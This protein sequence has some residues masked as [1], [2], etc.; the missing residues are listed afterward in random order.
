NPQPST[1]FNSNPLGGNGFAQ[2][3]AQNNDSQ[4]QT[5]PAFPASPQ[6]QP[7]FS[8]VQQPANGITAPVFNGQPTAPTI[9]ANLNAGGFNPQV[10]AVP[11]PNSALPNNNTGNAALNSIDNG[12]FRPNQ[13]PA[14]GATGSPGIAGVASKFKGPSIKTYRERT[15][16]EE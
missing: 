13:A 3:P 16:Y 9:S 1:L 8:P 11:Q 7:P 15:K 12:L 6:Q 2:A 14:A 10:P 5:A 4:N